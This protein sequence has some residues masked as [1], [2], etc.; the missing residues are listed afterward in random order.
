MPSVDWTRHGRKLRA[1]FLYW[2]GHVENVQP[3]L[4]SPGDRRGLRDPQVDNVNSFIFLPG[5]Q[6]DFIPGGDVYEGDVE[7]WADRE[8]HSKANPGGNADPA[9]F[10]LNPIFDFEARPRPA[11]FDESLTKLLNGKYRTRIEPDLWKKLPS[12]PNDRR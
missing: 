2:D 4:P 9:A 6:N 1:Q 8:R 11:L 7:E 5:E 3:K 10:T 12:D